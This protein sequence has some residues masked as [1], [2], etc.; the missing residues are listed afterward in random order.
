V[1]AR[2]LKTEPVRLDSEL[3]RLRRRIAAIEKRRAELTGH[4]AR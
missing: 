3:R 1:K 2:Q 4:G